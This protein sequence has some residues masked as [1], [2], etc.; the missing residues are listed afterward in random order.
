MSVIFVSD[1]L[2]IGSISNDPLIFAVFNAESVDK[3]F[4]KFPWILANE[5]LRS[6]IKGAHTLRMETA[7]LVLG[8]G[9]FIFALFLAHF[10]VVFVLSKSH[11]LFKFLIT[12]VYKSIE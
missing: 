11:L 10:T 12:I 1:D 7:F 6:V 3:L 2:V 5:E 9:I 8:E 4:F